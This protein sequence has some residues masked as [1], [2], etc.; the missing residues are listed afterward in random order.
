[1]TGRPS[2]RLLGETL[3]PELGAVAD[4]VQGAAFPPGL[5]SQGPPFVMRHVAALQGVVNSSYDMP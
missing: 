3:H 1:M 5:A 4:E 2:E